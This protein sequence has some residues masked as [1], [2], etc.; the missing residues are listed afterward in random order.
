V[1]AASLKEQKD[2]LNM[3]K[4][5][6]ILS[7]IV[8]LFGCGQTKKE[9]TLQTDS[10][11]KQDTTRT[12]LTSGNDSLENLMISRNKTLSAYYKNFQIH[13]LNEILRE[14]FN[15][16]KIID[17]AEFIKIAGKSGIIITDGK[18]SRKTHLCF[19][20]KFFYFTDFNW[21][22][23]WG[24]LKDSTTFE[25]LFDKN[26]GDIIGDTIIKLKNISIFVEE[27]EF[28]GGVITYENDKYKWVHQT[29]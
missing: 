11:T 4:Q 24:V 27:D 14:D 17:K 19:G 15:G 13:T 10:E 16:D 1:L 8:L 29:E 28:N 7:T 20:K 25:I 22:N 18:S 12:S 5:L 26:T 9:K 3:K 2:N 6:V 23:Y 21:A